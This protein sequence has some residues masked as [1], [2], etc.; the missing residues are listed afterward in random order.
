MKEKLYQLISQVMGIKPESITEQTGPDNI[1][2]WDSFNALMLVSE[3][4]NNFKVKLSMAE[5]MAVKNVGDIIKV[6]KKCGIN[7]DV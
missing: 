3:V 1:E 4:E 5:V 2:S 7:F 6:L